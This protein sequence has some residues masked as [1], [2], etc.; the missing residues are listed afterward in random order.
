MSKAINSTIFSPNKKHEPIKKLFPPAIV[1][2]APVEPP[3]ISAGN[4]RGMGKSDKSILRII[5]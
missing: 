3:S 5:S 1:N 2:E 4:I